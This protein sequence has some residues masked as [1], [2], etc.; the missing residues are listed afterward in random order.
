MPKRPN[1]RKSGPKKRPPS[2]RHQHAARPSSPLD[3]VAALLDRDHPLGLLGLVSSL[4]QTLEP[5]GP[6][7]RFQQDDD[8]D[9]PSR[10]DFVQA[11]LATPALETSAVLTAAAV[12]LGDDVLASRVRR[13]VTARAD[14]LP[15]W[16]NHLDRTR[17]AERALTMAHALGDGENVLIGATLPGGAELT[18][19]V[20]VDHNMGTLV[21]DAFAVP[22][23]VPEVLDRLTSVT[24]DPDLAIAEL[25][26]ADARAR[27]T[28]AIERGSISF[29][30]IETESWPA[31]RPLLE[32]VLRMVPAGGTGYERPELDEADRAALAER[33][34]ASPFAGGL[35][36]AALDQLDDL[37]W[38]G[39]DYGPGDPLRWSPVNVE[40][41]L[42]DWF[43]RKIIGEADDL[44]ALPDL[45]RA[46][47]RFA[48]AE[49]GIRA[50]LTAETIAAVDEWE[51]DYQAAIHRPRLQGV[52]ALFATVARLNPSGDFGSARLDDLR[53]AVGGQTA[54]AALDFAP[55]PDEPFAWSGVPGPLR[56]RVGEVL[57][58]VD[59]GCTELFDVEHRTAARRLLTHLAAEAPTVLARGRADTTAAAICWIVARVNGH[60]ERHMS[61]F[62][63]AP[64]D[65]PT[66]VELVRHFGVSPSSPYARGKVLLAALGGRTT[67][68]DELVLGSPDYLIGH[69]RGRFVA[70]RDALGVE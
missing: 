38:F 51:P 57:A 7:A 30:T 67:S 37:L 6:A 62:G 70:L 48:H 50:E 45:L 43:P 49:R 68:R 40:I 10:E 46:F 2:R 17:P 39:C 22:A 32:W 35:S 25:P 13:E 20:Y 52:D 26:S 16:L 58:L 14:V 29:P 18:F 64:P 23:A 21:K 44:A 12:L 28:E 41:L 56:D 19:V 65:G 61:L 36:A 8:P 27:V 53:A 42:L 5:S 60:F 9:I 66:M 11:M 55:L 47:I 69:R 4:L 59:D 24:D 33:F 34:R 54:L 1:R 15:A 31:C 3:D 63:D